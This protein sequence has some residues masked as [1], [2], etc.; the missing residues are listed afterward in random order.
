MLLGDPVA[1]SKSPVFQNAGLVAL[2]SRLRFGL[3][4]VDTAGARAAVDEIR[5]G[6]LVGANVTAPHKATAF[7]AVD[8]VTERAAATGAVNTIWRDADGQA[9]GDNTDVHG[10][11]AT[12]DAMGIAS[13]GGASGL[14]VVFGAGGAAAAAVL[15]CGRAF[16]RV[17]VVNRTLERAATLCASLGE[18]SA[19]G[20][21][22]QAWDAEV[23]ALLRRASVVVNATSLQF[24]D[25]ALAD[26]A[27]RSA[28]LEACSAR[29]WLDLSYAPE[30]T[31]FLRFAPQSLAAEG[32]TRDGATM[33]LHQGAAALVRWTGTEAPLEVMRAALADALGRPHGAV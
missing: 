23:P 14:V 2:G 21:S 30:T 16:D 9:R 6:E 29:A 1:H 31:R 18:W 10:V 11:S 25:A 17:V 5:R 3:R 26:T 8:A 24:S 13:D 19:A 4:R 20:L 33:L 32:L 12:L 28:G 7:E 22:A 27:W 15:A